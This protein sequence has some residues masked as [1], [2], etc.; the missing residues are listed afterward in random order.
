MDLRVKKT[1]IALR[2]AFWEIL[3]REGLENTTVRAVCERAMVNRATFYRHYEDL[4][5]I[6]TRG[7]QEFLDEMSALMDPP[8]YSTADFNTRVPPHNVLVMLNYVKENAEFFR[9]A[10]GE[11]GLPLFVAQFRS[12]FEEFVLTRIWTILPE[13]ARP[14]VPPSLTAKTLIGEVLAIYLWWLERD[15][16]PAP[17]IVAQY[18]LALVVHNAYQCIDMPTPHMT[19]ETIEAL[20]RE[21]AATQEHE[22]KEST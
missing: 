12:F 7:T 17:E 16:S 19:E 20:R 8:P 15:C 5:D 18:V 14:I 13:D 9:F 10:L 22:R 4:H 21:T 1:R 3:M 6:L 11:R 2:E